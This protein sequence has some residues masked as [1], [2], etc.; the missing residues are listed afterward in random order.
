M[1][2]PGGLEGS[3][4]GKEDNTCE[5]IEVRGSLTSKLYPCLVAQPRAAYILVP[6]LVSTT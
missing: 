5:G 2:I 4:H 1:S 6:N 3:F